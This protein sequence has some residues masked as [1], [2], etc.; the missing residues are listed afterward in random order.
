MTLE[1]SDAQPRYTYTPFP[2]PTTV[3]PLRPYYVPQNADHYYTPLG[4]VTSNQEDRSNKLMNEESQGLI[5]EVFSLGLLKYISTAI[6]NPFEVSK[7]LLQVQY[8]PNEDVVPVTVESDNAALDSDE[9]AS[10]D[11]GIYNS[12]RKTL[13]SNSPGFRQ[14]KNADIHGYIDTNIYDE[15]TRPA[16]MVPPLEHG[17][18]ETVKTLKGHQTEG[19]R[20][21]WKGQFTNWLYEMGHVF[22]QPTFEGAL[23]D[24]FDLY[25]DTI[26]L[27]YLDRVG[28]N[29]ATL[30]VSHVV[31]GVIL[32]PLEV[33]R[34]RLVVQTASS[35]HKKYTGTFDCLRQMIKEE[36]FTSLYWSH[37]LIPSIVFHA[38][39]PLLECTVPLII[40][41]VFHINPADSPILYGLAQLG[42]NT[43]QLLITL[44]IETIR[45]RLHC[46]I[47][48]RTPGKS[49]E[50]VV[51][52]RKAPYVSMV[53]ATYRI[54]IEEG[55]SQ[56][57][58]PRH[59]N[60]RRRSLRRQRSWLDNYGVRRLYHG[61]YLHFTN[62]VIQF[63]FQIMNGVEDD[64]KDF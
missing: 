17:V 50:T 46:Q 7:T 12:S 9:E 42:L 49:F 61:F 24:A 38:V 10:D 36:G 15:S 1:A 28:P 33:V 14:S 21:L 48:S 20:S 60:H 39:C 52:T 8:L 16:Y 40:D 22:L 44:P 30:I 35:L 5:K 57:F 11:D 47:A 45:K 13:D 56:T 53:D 19:L 27:I 23:N 25:D 34:T 58:I 59:E 3:H 31:A 62:N 55:I 18:W 2:Q 54:I 4:N 64:F 43:L 37:N 32:S 29:I 6:S 41:R 51:Q 63:F 26:P